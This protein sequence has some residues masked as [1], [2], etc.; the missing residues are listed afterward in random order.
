VDATTVEEVV[1]ND[2]CAGQPVSGTTTLRTEDHTAVIVYD[3]ATDCDPDEN[4][5]LTVN[6]EDRGLVGGILCTVTDV[7]RA[8]GGPS[9]PAFLLVAA[10]IAARLR[11]R[12]ND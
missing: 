9:I 3:G 7:G 2:V 6:D 1:D 10:G 5:R 12:R 4:A 8:R 11:R